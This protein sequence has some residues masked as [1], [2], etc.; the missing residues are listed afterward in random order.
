MENGV[1][2]MERWKDEIGMKKKEM[3]RLEDEGL[4]TFLLS[5]D[6]L[7]LDGRRIV[8]DE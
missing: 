2:K 4:N 5:I 6:C 1:E 8:I 7:P 3:P